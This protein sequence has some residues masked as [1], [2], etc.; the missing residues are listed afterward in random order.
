MVSSLLAPRF[1]SDYDIMWVRKLLGWQSTEFD[2][3]VRCGTVPLTDLAHG[4]PLLLL[5]VGQ[6]CAPDI[7]LPHVARELRSLASPPDAACHHLGG[8]FRPLLRNVCGRTTVG[9]P[10]PALLNTASHREKSNPPR[11]LLLLEQEQAIDTVHRPLS[12]DNWDCWREDW[13]I[14]QVKF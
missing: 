8:D 6:A 14:V 4:G 10:V 7:L 9:A 1:R 13:V 5:R 3:K 12:P 2:G 11:G